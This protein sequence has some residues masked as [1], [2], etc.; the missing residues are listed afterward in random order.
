[1]ELIDH[2]VEGIDNGIASDIDVA[3]CLLLLEVLLRKWG[4]REVISSDTTGNLTVHLLW[5]RAVDVVCTKTCLYVSDRDLG[6]ECSQCA[7]S[8]GS[9]IAMNE[10]DIGTAFFEDVAKA[11]EG[12]CCYIG[13]VLPLLHDVE[14]VV[15]SYI[16]NLKHLV[17][18][19]AMLA[20]DTNYGFELRGA[21]LEFLDQR[22]HLNGLRT[23]AKYE[24]YGFHISYI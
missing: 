10:Y 13:K 2:H 6:I 18:H 1:M 22:A 23:S 16:E 17:K 3:M 20:G 11:G 8:G 5:P 15:R 7:S 9:S 21:L 12:T 4:W 24:H 14:V 19:F